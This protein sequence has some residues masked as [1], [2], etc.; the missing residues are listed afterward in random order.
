MTEYATGEWSPNFT[1]LL[2]T[3]F[4]GALRS[5]PYEVIMSGL[6]G[7]YRKS[8]VDD[9]THVLNSS[10]AAIRERFYACLAL[11][12]WGESSGYLAV[13]KAANEGSRAPWYGTSIDRHYS[14]DDTF[15]R[16]A[17]AAG[18]SDEMAELNGSLPERTAALREII[19]LADTE[20]FGNQL[21]LLLE[22]ELIHATVDDLARVI[23][24]GTET[25]L[26]DWRPIFPLGAQLVDLAA[27]VTQVDESLGVAL[28][29]DLVKADQT[30]STLWHAVLVVHWGRGSPS[31]EFGE[32]L[33]A[34]SDEKT[35]DE[36]SEAIRKR[37]VP[38]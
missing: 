22:P 32:Y 13:A 8:R 31:L 6:N 1:R 35:R 16:L 38:N 10:S 20:Y 34:I 27:A 4:D 17:E 23:R 30:H 9:L 19:G 29:T 12:A 33:S 11:T 36:V 14:L 2:L 7:V 3:D 5:D 24:K 25:L 18:D 15:A 28:A 37:S 21:H 26:T